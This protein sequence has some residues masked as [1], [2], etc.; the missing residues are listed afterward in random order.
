[1]SEQHF[2]GCENVEQFL[3]LGREKPLAVGFELAPGRVGFEK[4]FAEEFPP[5]EFVLG[6]RRDDVRCLHYHPPL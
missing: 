1:V 5:V 4:P 6:R 2:H 3:G